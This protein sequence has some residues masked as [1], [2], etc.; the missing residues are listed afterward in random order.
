LATILAVAVGCGGGGTAQST[1]S[2]P[3]TVIDYFVA[4][5]S[6]G[7]GASLDFRGVDRVTGALRRALGGGRGA[8][9]AIASVLNDS[10][11]VLPPPTFVAVLRDG[12]T[13][14]LRPVRRILAGRDD[15]A[16]RRA[17]ALMPPPGALSPQAATSLYLAAPGISPL[18]VTAVRMM[19]A[20]GQVVSMTPQGR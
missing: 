11:R 17:R 20:A 4:R 18:D 3:P 8:V 9:L 14:P 15:P 7:I 10:A 1:R 13:L 19:T 12:R 5:G 16:A 2:V 6:D